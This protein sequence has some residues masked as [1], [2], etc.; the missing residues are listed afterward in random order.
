MK[1]LIENI[2]AHIS[3]LQKEMDAFENCGNKA[4]GLRARKT[5]FALEKL[6]KEFRKR[7]IAESKSK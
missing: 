4:A 1:E 3:V 6:F 2:E 7:S 5:S